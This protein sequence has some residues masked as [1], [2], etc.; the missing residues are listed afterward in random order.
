MWPRA[1][2]PQWF[3]DQTKWQLKDRFL[4]ASDRKAIRAA[5]AAPV[6]D[7]LA[8]VDIYLAAWWRTRVE[9]HKRMWAEVRDRT[10]PESPA[11]DRSGPA[12]LPPGP[13]WLRG[14]DEIWLRAHGAAVTEEL[15]AQA[16]A[17]GVGGWCAT[18]TGVAIEVQAALAELDASGDNFQSRWR[19]ERIVTALDA[20]V[21]AA[22][23][24]E[25]VSCR[26]Q[27]QAAARQ[28]R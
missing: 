3:R 4:T 22:R 19:L 18:V 8:V 1:Q 15:R 24:L 27:R 12:K 25:D 6:V 26:L 16:L 21:A 17:L 9:V 2:V 5:M 10:P 23:R 14:L 11:H 28:G 7:S 13:P 20:D